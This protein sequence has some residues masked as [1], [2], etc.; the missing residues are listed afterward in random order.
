MKEM[1]MNQ[2]AETTGTELALPNK[3][4]IAAMFREP[5]Q[6]DSLLKRIADEAKSL[7]ADVSTAKGRDAVRSMA[8]KVARSKTTLDDAGKALN[9]A[10]RAQINVVDAERAKIRKALDALKDEVRAPLTKWETDEADRVQKLK[11]RLERVRLAHT[12]LPDDAAADQ[13]GALLARVETIAIDDT[14]SEFTADAARFK[15]QA[16]A[17]LR[18]MRDDKAKREAEAAELA[19]LR[20]EAAA[21]EEADRLAREKAEADRI[22]KEAEERRLREIQEAATRAAQQAEARAQALAA[23]QAAEAKAAADKAAR[24]AAERE[25]ALRRQIEAERAREEKAR[26]DAIAERLAAEARHAKEM[27]DAEAARERA[28]QAERDRL[29]AEAKADADAR[30]KREADQAHKARIKANIVTALEAMRGASSP[31]DIADAIIA[32]KIPHV[33]AL[34]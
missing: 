32:G 19:R 13:V 23:Q 26:Q 8:F 9:E 28:A 21:R 14:W 12:M 10:A 2:V 4:A 29:A 27:A 15:D 34:I 30:A 33:M 20:A 5:E 7:T 1:D 11:D 24:D 3:A 25:E 16:V 22:A 18:T 31:S 6:V 17:T